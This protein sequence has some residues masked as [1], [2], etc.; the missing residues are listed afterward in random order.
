MGDVVVSQYATGL[1]RDA[2]GTTSGMTTCHQKGYYSYYSYYSAGESV[3]T[4]G[5][6]QG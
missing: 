1:D 6:Y 5:W 3:K 4:M 2:I